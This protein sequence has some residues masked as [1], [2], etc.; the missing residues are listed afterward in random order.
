MNTDFIIENG[1]LIKYRGTG[2]YVEI[3]DGVTS[4]GYGAFLRSENLVSV[5]FPD[6]VTKVGQKVFGDCTSLTEISFG[7]G[8]TAISSAM[9]AGCTALTSIVIPDTVKKV[10]S[11]AFGKCASLSE[12]V[13]GK[14]M[15][16]ISSSMFQD[17]TALTSI[18]IPEHIRFISMNAFRL[19]KNLRSVTLMPTLERIGSA[20]F[21]ECAELYEIKMPGGIPKIKFSDETSI[22]KVNQNARFFVRVYLFGDKTQNDEFDSACKEYILKN[23]FAC[24]YESLCVNSIVYAKK[25]IEVVGRV[26]EDKLI[27]LIDFATERNQ[28]DFREFF[29]EIKNKY[30]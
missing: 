30:Y 7:K 24:L 6:S 27:R 13:F 28:E 26:E 18:V 4:I 21:S 20:A 16:E 23:P 12:V 5:K 9:F 1:E 19:C 14:G 25:L 15:N 22:I 17:C 8:M 3:P 11:M 2:T 29:L 10:G